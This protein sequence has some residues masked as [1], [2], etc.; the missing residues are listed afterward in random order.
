MNDRTLVVCGIGVPRLGL[1]T[2][3]LVGQRCTA[4]VREA[5]AIGY[6]HFDTAQTYGNEEAIGLA[7]KQKRLERE[8]LY[9]VTKIAP[10]N[11]RRP[12]VLRSVEHS[13]RAMRVDYFDLVLLHWPPRS[14]LASE[15]LDALNELADRQKLL[16]LG[17]SNWEP[18]AFVDIAQR[19]DVRCHQ[20]E[21]HPYIDQR[22]SL[23]AAA[24]ASGFV[25][26]YCPLARGLVARDPAI[27][28]I[29]ARYRKTSAQVT[30]RWL[31]QQ[32][33]IVAIPGSSKSSHLA[34]NF[35][36]FDFALDEKDMKSISS[37]ANG[38][39]LVADPRL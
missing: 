30:L 28:A 16:T 20:I 34:E 31:L 37:L 19:H 18:A 39:K 27:G 10:K 14:T 8:S 9:L 2:W 38:L 32:P 17:V 23:R 12:Q 35:N 26:A 3:G 1:G 33:G 5:L 24:D 6:R 7:L 25:T 21:Y 15:A 36:V 11:E 22:A 4:A 29:A 13:L